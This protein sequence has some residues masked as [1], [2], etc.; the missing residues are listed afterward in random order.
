[1]L[2]VIIL[3]FRLLLDCFSFSQAPTGSSSAGCWSIHGRESQRQDVCS[4]LIISF[5]PKQE[6]L[7]S[8]TLWGQR[9]VSS[10][11]HF[12]MSLLFSITVAERCLRPVNGVK[13]ISQEKAKVNSI[14]CPLPG[15]SYHCFPCP[16]ACV[17]EP[18]GYPREFSVMSPLLW[19]LHELP[20]GALRHR[21][22]RQGCDVVIN[23]AGEK[24]RASC[25]RLARV[26]W[27]HPTAKTVLIQYSIKSFGVPWQDP[28]RRLT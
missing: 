11:G 28:T 25:L 12:L 8:L 22:G 20:V 13:K 4:D 6:Q 3:V 19:L 9:L 23:E 7:C 2:R 15:W 16:L 17:K 14:P 26:S 21:S 5:V 24:G 10:H 1:M 27:G 18:P